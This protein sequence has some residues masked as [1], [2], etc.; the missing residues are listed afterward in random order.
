MFDPTV[1]HRMHLRHS[2]VVSCQALV[3]L[4]ELLARMPAQARKDVLEAQHRFLSCT[5]G[6]DARLIEPAT[7]GATQAVDWNA[8]YQQHPTTEEGAII[9]SSYSR[10]W[11]EKTPPVVEYIVQS[12]DGAFEEDEEADYSAR[13]TWAVF[14]IFNTDN[15]RV[16]QSILQGKKRHEVQRYHAILLEP[17]GEKYLSAPSSAS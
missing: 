6:A 16:L 8:L 7:G 2:P 15:A 13:T 17:G 1:C 4:K 10:Q 5:G 12:I 11:P 14:D 3:E 9:K